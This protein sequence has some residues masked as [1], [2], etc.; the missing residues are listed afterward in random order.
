MNRGFR[1]LLAPHPGWVALAA[2]AS[3]FLAL[4]SVALFDLDEGAFTAA[5]WE[6]SERGSYWFTYLNG[7]PR[8][9]KPIFSYWMQ[10]LSVATL[11]ADEWSY[12]LP[13]AVAATLWVVLVVRF[14][15][16][17]FDRTSA[18]LAGVVLAGMLAVSVIGRAAT[19]DAWLNLFLTG[20]MLSAWR[21]HAYFDADPAATRRIALWTYAFMGLGFL[22]K[23]PVAVVVPVAVMVLFWASLPLRF[24]SSAPV[25]A[26]SWRWEDGWQ[27]FKAALWQPMGWALF[28]AIVGPWYAIAIA[29]EGWAFIDGF[30]LT[31]NLSRYTETFESHGGHLAYYVLA[32]PLIVLPFTAWLIPVVRRAPRDLKATGL[33]RWLWLWFGFVFVFFSF[34]N[35]QLPHY[36]LYGIVP[37]AIL[38]A[39][40]RHGVDGRLGA[41]WAILPLLALVSLF[42]ALPAIVAGVDLAEQRPLVAAQLAHAQKRLAETSM[43]VPL[44]V[45]IILIVL[46]WWMRNKVWRL[47]LVLGLLQASLLALWLAPLAAEIRQAPVRDLAQMS[48]VLAPPE[49]AVLTQWGINEFRSAI[50]YRR[51]LI[52]ERYPEP[53]EWG[54]TTVAGFERWQSETRQPALIAAQRAEFVLVYACRAPRTGSTLQQA[55]DGATSIPGGDSSLNASARNV[56]PATGSG[57]P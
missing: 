46:A 14:V 10:A 21:F 36:L 5:T 35:T 6:M 51:A 31:H 2:F 55:D 23:G 52:P 12:R 3:F 37:V 18:V 17:F 4:G 8:F 20:A 41:L 43:T 40:A 25:A 1:R 47:L 15:R 33:M 34:S 48:R 27:R 50:T 29:L 30:F 24:G 57:C 49:R 16:E 53:G 26:R 44:L 9:D 56:L 38:I 22:T 42:L 54:L 28:V 7:E 32:L 19:A 11:G 45:A 13:S 39:R